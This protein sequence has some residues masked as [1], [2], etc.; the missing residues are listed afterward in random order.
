LADA[1]RGA[2]D[3]DW[4]N[5]FSLPFDPPWSMDWAETWRLMLVLASDP[6][7]QV[8]PALAGWKHPLSRESIVLL[9]LFDLQHTSKAKRRPKAYP[10]PWDAEKKSYGKGTAVSLAEYR[11]LRKRLEGG[12]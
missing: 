11:A 6:S 7:S 4:R 10:R 5:R 1:H 9:D 12:S 3:Y 2:F 8:A